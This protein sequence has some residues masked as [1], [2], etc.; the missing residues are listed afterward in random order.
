MAVDWI[1]ALGANS[2]RPICLPEA[3]AK[4]KM[5]VQL[6]EWLVSCVPNKNNKNNEIEMRVKISIKTKINVNRRQCILL[7]RQLITGKK[8]VVRPAGATIASAPRSPT[9]IR[10]NMKNPSEPI[11]YGVWLIL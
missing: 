5:E 11:N 7:W 6:L 9:E 3:L 10:F 1:A 8:F 4:K 2:N